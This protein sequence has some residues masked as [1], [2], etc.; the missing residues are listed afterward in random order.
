ME[1]KQVDPN[2]M[3]MVVLTAR[4]WQVMHRAMLEHPCPYLISAPI[5]NKLEEQLM[6]GT[7]PGQSIEDAAMEAAAAQPAPPPPPAP[8][9]VDNIIMPD[10][11]PGMQ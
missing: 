7:N 6:A 9:D 10:T 3:I 11:G 2:F 1:M 8:T 4:E 5:I